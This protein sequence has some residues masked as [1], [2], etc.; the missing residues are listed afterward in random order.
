MGKSY[1]I[2]PAQQITYTVSATNENSSY[3]DDNL[4]DRDPQN[5]FKATTTATTITL[6]HSSAARKVI[7]VIN[8][9][10][11][12]GASTFTAGGVAVT[13]PARTADGQAV[14]PFQVLDLTAATSTSVVI[15]GAS[16]TVQIGEIVLASAMTELNWTWGLDAPGVAESYEWPE[17]ELRT[18]YRKSLIYDTGIRVRRAEGKLKR[19]AER[20]VWRAIAQAA[21]GRAIP[22]VFIPDIDVND[23]WYVRLAESSLEALRRMTNVTDVTIALEEV[24]NGL[25]L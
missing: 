2:S 25:V 22:F 23:C 21:K 10:V 11:L 7:A 15:S 6:S 17:R 1:V 19:E 24:S 4:L 3:P 5:P 8:P 20:V 18:F 12:A 13:C 14:N 9:S 16:A